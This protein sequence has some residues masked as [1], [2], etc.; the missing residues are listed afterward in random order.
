MAERKQP[1]PELLPSPWTD[2]SPLRNPFTYSNSNS[3]DSERGSPLTSA[4]SSPTCSPTSSPIS[5]IRSHAFGPYLR[6]ARSR[7]RTSFTS[8]SPSSF[9][10]SS[11]FLRR[12]PSTVD[13]ALSEERSRCSADETERKSLGL[14]EPR[15]VDPM[16]ILANIDEDGNKTLGFQVEAKTTT[17]NSSSATHQPR[18]VMGGIFEVMEGAA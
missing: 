15:P 5:A 18:Y 7:S 8:R 13:L 17:S 11:L 16:P 12:R 2:F 10:L 14:M 1:T 4:T 6:R 3:T 9:R